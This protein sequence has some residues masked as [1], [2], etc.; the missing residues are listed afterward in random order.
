[1]KWAGRGYVY[2]KD[3]YDNANAN[4][5]LV[6]LLT[7]LLLFGLHMLNQRVEWESTREFSETSQTLITAYTFFGLHKERRMCWLE[8]FAS[9]I[10]CKL[11]GEF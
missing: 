4:Y 10:K 11:G 2:E 1:M 5:L 3:E 6:L 7:F 9:L 8:N